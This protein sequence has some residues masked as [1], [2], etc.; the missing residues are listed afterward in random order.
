MTNSTTP[1]ENIKEV[2]SIRPKRRGAKNKS[3]LP[4]PPTMKTEEAVD[5]NSHQGCEVMNFLPFPKSNGTFV[6]FTSYMLLIYIYAQILC[7]LKMH[8]AAAR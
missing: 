8:C 5:K 1:K 7:K 6:I 4:E 2:P 3:L